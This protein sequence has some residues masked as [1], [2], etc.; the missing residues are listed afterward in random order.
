MNDR[1]IRRRPSTE[2]RSHAYLKTSDNLSTGLAHTHT[3]TLMNSEIF[4]FLIEF[5]L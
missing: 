4:I 1:F 3:H 5:I 2:G